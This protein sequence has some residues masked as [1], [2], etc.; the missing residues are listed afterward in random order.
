MDE[1]PAASP[2]GPA[3]AV[4]SSPLAACSPPGPSSPARSWAARPTPLRRRPRHPGRPRP[5]RGRAGDARRGGGGLPHRLEALRRRVGARHPPDDRARARPGDRRAPR[6]PPPLPPG[7]AP[8]GGRDAPPRHLGL[9][10][11][12]LGRRAHR[13]PRHRRGPRLPRLRRPRAGRAPRSVDPSTP[14]APS[15]TA[16]SRPSPGA[17]SARPTASSRPTPARPTPATSRR[18]SAPSASTRASPEPTAAP[19]SPA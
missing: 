10:A 19:S 12:G 11:R 15:T 5:R 16:S 2:R 13:A 3:G 9:R 6:A 7:D 1:A 14:T 17:S 18:W 8:R 4:G